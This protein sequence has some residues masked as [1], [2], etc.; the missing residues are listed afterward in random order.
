MIKEHELLRPLVSLGLAPDHKIARKICFVL[1]PLRNE[2]EPG[3]EITLQLQDFMKI[4]KSDRCQDKLMEAL[5]AKT[6]G[7]AEQ[8]MRIQRK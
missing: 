6:R 2:R 8:K 7:R 1:D 5:E 3:E 4:F